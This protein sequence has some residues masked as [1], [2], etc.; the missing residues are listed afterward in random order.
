MCRTPTGHYHDH[1]SKIFVEFV[2]GEQ[3][4]AQMECSKKFK[5]SLCR[6]C[7]IN[8]EE[9]RVCAGAW[10]RRVMPAGH[11]DVTLQETLDPVLELVE[12]N[13]L[14]IDMPYAYVIA[15]LTSAL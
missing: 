12:W 2:N 7:V 10:K 5:V 1:D 3:C 6:C 15:T 14:C 8:A 11:C 9:L 13:E 4:G